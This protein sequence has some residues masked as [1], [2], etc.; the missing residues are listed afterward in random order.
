L[1]ASEAGASPSAAGSGGA[2]VE[3][4]TRDDTGPGLARGLLDEARQVGNALGGGKAADR[5][6]GLLAVGGV[7]P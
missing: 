3:R 6:H 5:T 2:W 4:D 1:I 7:D